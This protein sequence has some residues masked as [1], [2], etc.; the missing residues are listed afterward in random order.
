MGK[1]HIG[2]IAFRSAS[3][4]NTKI[5]LCFRIS[6]HVPT[7]FF[8]RSANRFEIELCGSSL[9]RT[10]PVKCKF[11]SVFQIKANFTLKKLLTL[12]ATCSFCVH[13]ASVEHM[14]VYKIY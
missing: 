10:V 11:G 13:T 12:W 8:S 9:D 4:T 7:Y 2:A 14:E 1:Y 3:R 6:V 5:F